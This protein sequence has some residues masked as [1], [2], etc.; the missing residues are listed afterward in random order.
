MDEEYEDIE[1]TGDQYKSET[2]QKEAR[3]ARRQAIYKNKL[4]NR[5]G[6]EYL[7]K[8]SDRYIRSIKNKKVPLSG[9]ASVH[10]SKISNGDFVM[11]MLVACFFD[12]LSFV[13]NLL[14][15]IGGVVA[16]IL[17]TIPG[18]GILWIMYSRLGINMKSSR[19]SK[20][21]WGSAIIEFIPV[22][23]ALPA[24]IA[25]VMLVTASEKLPKV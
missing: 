9:E 18:N 20:R 10:S 17:S 14:P 19:V 23:N 8:V 7:Q 11:L 25:N 24:M 21:F 15:V 16:M 12:A 5:E 6:R 13:L 22:V 4:E 2:E 1:D 3:Q